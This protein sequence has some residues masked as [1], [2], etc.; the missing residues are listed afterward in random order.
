MPNSPFT[1]NS[2]FVTF[3]ITSGGSEIPGE[4]EVTDIRIEQYVNRIAEAEIILLDGNAAQQEF[5]IA[6]SYNFIP[7]SEIEIKLGYEG[8]ND[9]IFKGVVVKQI[10]KIDQSTGSRLHVIC[11]DKCLGMAINR[12][13]RIFTDI[14]DSDLI[15][16]IAGDSGLSTDITATAVQHKEI[17]QYYC[18]DWDFIMNRAELNGLVV[19]TNGGKLIAAK[20]DVS[21]T[22]ELSMTFGDDILEF[23]GEIDATYQY[24]GVEGNCWDP[25]SQSVVNAKA[26]EP[27]VNNQGNITGSKLADV[28]NSGNN[29]INSSVAL[30]QDH[31]QV[32]V[33][34]ALLKSR[35]SQYKGS[36]TFQGSN[37]ARPNATIELNGLGDR[38]NGNAYI[39]G[40]VHN[41]SEGRWFT[42][43]RI[44]LSAEW[45]VDKHPVVAP[46][47]SGLIPGIKGLQTGIVKKIDSDPDN[48][49][50]VQVEIPIL[51]AEG[52]YVWARLCSFYTG[53]GFGA[54]FKP[55]LND[56]VILGFMNDDPR[57]PVI[58]GSVFSSSISPSE[59]PEEKNNIKTLLTREGMQIK[60]D[61][62]Y[63][64]ITVL[65]PGGNT[66]ILSDEDQ[67]ITITD[68]NSNEIQ[69]N[70]AGIVLDSKSDLT[71][72]AAQGV[73]VQG[74]T[75]S[76][77]GDQSLRCSSLQVSILADTETDI[78][79]G[80]S[81]SVSSSGNMSVKGA[82][83]M[84]N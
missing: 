82:M 30:D 9:S 19:T 33:D 5:K 8:K 61:E 23:E 7:G 34:S 80:A 18:T 66:L 12:K 57:F 10:I 49:F 25:G 4:Y 1:D 16:Q 44:G 58:L 75:I 14:K 59:T 70:G 32:W 38:F 83:V 21:A 56:E 13:N 2:N 26:K 67:G 54:Y 31:V 45:F 55:E 52:K 77:N 28:L 60:F 84:V 11:K 74:G 6:D 17:V 3:A 40:V 81:C 47:A 51:G 69:M 37:K 29:Q 41:L 22:P 39:S 72:R 68:Q 63:K 46:N 15:S 24:A 65:T 27:T 53:S 42:E 48:E 64:I 43:A 20:P 71:L 36:I 50:R 35:L 76:I 79:G 78:R 62:E 73:T